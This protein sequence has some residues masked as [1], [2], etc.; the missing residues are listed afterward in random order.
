MKAETLA[1]SLI[2]EY[3]LSH[4]LLRPLRKAIDNNYP[5]NTI[6]SWLESIK[7]RNP[8][9]QEAYFN[10][11]MKR[12]DEQHP[13]KQTETHRRPIPADHDWKICYHCGKNKSCNYWNDPIEDA[14]HPANVSP[15]IKDYH[16]YCEPCYH[17][18]IKRADEIYINSGHA[19]A[20]TEPAKRFVNS[21]SKKAQLKL[22]KLFT[23]RNIDN[24]EKEEIV[25][26]LIEGVNKSSKSE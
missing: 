18:L 5:E 19:G 17:E 15:Q 2:I 9:N 8:E 20:L 7:K 14:R 23:G 26:G 10:G 4:S 1:E 3:N 22:D 12:Y 13:Q 21:L 24:S 6:R 25:E 16:W 11:C